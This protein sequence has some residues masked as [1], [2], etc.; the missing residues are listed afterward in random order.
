MQQKKIM[1]VRIDNYVTLLEKSQIVYMYAYSEK[2]AT[3]YCIK[4]CIQSCELK[5]H[6]RTNI[7]DMFTFI[8][9]KEVYEVVFTS[10]VIFYFLQFMVYAFQN[11]NY[12]ALYTETVNWLFTESF[13]ILEMPKR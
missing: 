12:N 1:H 3:N 7:I 13:I 4:D 8:F 6:G 9:Q 10:F 11:I 2:R 5:Q